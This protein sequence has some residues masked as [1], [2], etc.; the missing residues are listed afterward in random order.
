MIENNSDEIFIKLL[1][2]IS[3]IKGY[4]LTTINTIQNNLRRP[5]RLLRLVNTKEVLVY[6]SD[7]NHTYDICQSTKELLLL[8]KKKF[9]HIEIFS[10]II[11]LFPQFF[12]NLKVF[13]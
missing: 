9:H 2:N 4:I 12:S 7:I 10:T 5:N 13:K 1:Q 11:C 6:S 8:N 3:A